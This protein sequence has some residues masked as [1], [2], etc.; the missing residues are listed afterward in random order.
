MAFYTRGK[1]QDIQ[2]KTIACAHLS[3]NELLQCKNL[4]DNH[5]GVWGD[6]HP[7]KGE[8]IKFPTKL[9]QQYREKCSIGITQRVSGIWRLSPGQQIKNGS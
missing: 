6:G 1:I 4:F 9:Y 5:Y 8:K 2:F 7:R 3:D